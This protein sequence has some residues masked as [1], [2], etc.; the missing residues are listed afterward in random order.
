MARATMGCLGQGCDGAASVSTQH[1]FG[2][3]APGN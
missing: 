3:F 1:M 2:N